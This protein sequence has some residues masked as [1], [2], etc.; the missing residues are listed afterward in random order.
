MKYDFS[1]FQN[2]LNQYLTELHYA[3][4]EDNCDGIITFTRVN[5]NH[6]FIETDIIADGHQF[7]L[8]YSSFELCDRADK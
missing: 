2:A 1:N 7:L 5:E 3:C 4:I 8:N 6:L